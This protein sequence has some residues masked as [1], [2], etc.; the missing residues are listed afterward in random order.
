[1]I[2]TPMCAMGLPTGPIEKAITY[3]VRPRMHP[4]NS[5]ARVLRMTVGSSQLLVGPAS[6]CV[7]EQMYVRSST[8]ATSEGS[9]QARYES[10]RLSGLSFTSIPEATISP[11]S[12]SY[13]CCEPS[14]Q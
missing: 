2:S 6:A 1:M 10:G 3:I 13:S 14:A 12:R 9:E 4:L 7:A 5:P 8:R 11:H